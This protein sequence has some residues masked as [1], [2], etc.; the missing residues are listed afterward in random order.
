MTA[1][2][3][4]LSAGVLLLTL[5]SFSSSCASSEAQERTRTSLRREGKSFTQEPSTDA[6]Q[7]DLDD[8]LDQLG[9]EEESGFRI[10][11]GFIEAKARA[12]LNDRNQDRKDEELLLRA[13]IEAEARFTDELS[14]Y[15]RSRLL[16]DTF[17]T[18]LHR[19]EPLEGYLTY[20]EDS[21]DLRVGQ[22]IENWGIV[23]TF[24]PI[25]VLNR[26]DLGTDILDPDRLGE[27][28]ARF[29]LLLPDGGAL[30][31]PTIS[32]YAMPLFRPIK[33]PPDDGRWSFDQPGLLFDDDHGFEPS[34][35]ESG[36]YALR[37]TGTM[38][39]KPVN[40][41]VQV[42]AS[43]GPERFPAIVPNPAFSRQVP[44]YYGVGTFGLGFRAVPNE[45]ALGEQLAK[46]TLKAE[47]IYKHPYTFAD[48]PI[49][50][51]DNYVA[52][53]VGVDRTFSSAI[54]DG[55][56]LIL[57]VEF[58]RE[59]GA[60]DPTSRLRPFRNDLIV[61]ALWNV[62]DFDRT[63]LEVRFLYDLDH[64]EAIG[65]IIAEHQLRFIDDNLKLGFQLQIFDPADRG[66]SFLGAF[67]NNSS[68]A[69]SL[70]WQF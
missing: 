32:L 7:D 61:R 54:T 49:D 59:W 19:F 38:N 58:A 45:A 60:G 35:L 43:A 50:A 69:I 48:S 56:D 2:R 3:A 62:N 67:P 39:T 40:A 65:E 42:I 26:R 13:E 41:D 47:A 10:L 30:R 11:R 27:L 51:P 16:L 9:A 64:G 5:I 22:F 33:F 52:M 53:V 44:V 24:N 28:G 70:R 23:D 17:N 31:E 68:L 12:Y 57:T 20:E 21:W 25:D 18:E 63:S 14:G 8:L 6:P 1:D 4:S 15:L 37:F 66:E 34:G 46:L 29:R 36:F 55:D